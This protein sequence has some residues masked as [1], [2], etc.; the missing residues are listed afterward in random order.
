MFQNGRIRILYMRNHKN[1]CFRGVRIAGQVCVA[2]QEE[3]GGEWRNEYT[4][5]GYEFAEDDDF[6]DEE[7]LK[8]K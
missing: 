1:W 5:M 2:G 8:V 4:D 6:Y 7:E 3:E